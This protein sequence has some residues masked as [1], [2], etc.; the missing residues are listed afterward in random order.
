MT[1]NEN[2]TLTTATA[3]WRSIEA[4]LQ[5]LVAESAAL[6]EQM[7]ELEEAGIIDAGEHWRPDAQKK[8][9]ILELVYAKNSEWVRSGKRRIK[10]IGKDPAKI[11]EVQAGRE[12][13][14]A[15]QE[16]EE[17]RGRVQGDIRCIKWGIER[18]LPNC[19]VMVQL[20]MD[21]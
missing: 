12:R 10:Y 19:G 3:A 18:V 17:R 2:D 5:R 11:A 8:R 9:T 21:I 20:E 14:A 1:K 16:L 13:F 6:T 4:T 7:R 15:W